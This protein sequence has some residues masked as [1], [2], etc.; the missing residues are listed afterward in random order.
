MRVARGAA[1][2]DLDRTLLRGASGPIL[3]DALV[4]AGVTSRRLPGQSLLYR[5]YDLF[6][7]T[8]LSIGLARLAALGARGVAP[9]DMLR[10]GE[11]AAPLLE[12]MV[13]PFAHPLLADHRRA[14][15]ALVLATTTPHDLVVPLAERL[16]FDGVVATRYAQRR[17]VY[18]GSIEKDF[19]WALGKLSSVRRWATEHGVRME[20]SFAYSD[21]FFDVPLL[22]AVGNPVAVHPDPR[23]R[24]VALVARW[25]I[26]HLDV[27]P[28]VP[29]VAGV[30]PFDVVRMLA[31]PEM[32]PYARFDIGPVDPIP[33]SGPAIIAANHR[34]YFDV[35]TLGL[36]LVRRGR[37]VRFLAK[38]ELFDAPVVGQIALA[39]GGI[40]VDRG[41]RSDEPLR[42]AARILE[43]G[44][45]VVVLPQG[46]IPRGR[47]FFEAKLEGKTGAARLA[48]MT[49]APVVP[50]GIWGTE[51]V[52]PR[53]SRI[54]RVTNVARPPRVRVRVGPPVELLLDDPH[55]D[56]A[57]IMD[58]IA[59]LLPEEA[60]R[61]REPTPEELRL[62]YPPGSG[63][64]GPGHT[65]ARNGSPNGSVAE[66]GRQA[67][68]RARP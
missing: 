15:R 41:S 14:G 23:L 28:G 5:A 2:F 55:A 18:T 66:Q 57:R 65:A 16:G 50:V 33:A 11:A 51:A 54:P 62:T 40:P 12:Q 42:G 63:P 68:R 32:F 48:A 47:A 35:A 13:S 49:G 9:E 1:F 58:A 60:R 52:W 64:P 24:A 43:A 36:A 20:E 37:P 17:G 56:T 19:V 4:A 26:V 59:K 53:N 29:K 10:A 44:E 3:S 7:E 67:R 31:R 6:G 21:S 8:A 38:K 45:L 27:P 22:S 25:P 34:S 46:T 30:E 61:S 39:L